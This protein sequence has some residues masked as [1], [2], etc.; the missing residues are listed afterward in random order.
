VMQQPGMRGYA[1]CDLWADYRL[2]RMAILLA[3][4]QMAC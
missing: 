2:G 1:V 4:R 3:V